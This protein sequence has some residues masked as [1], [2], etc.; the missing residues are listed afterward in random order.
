VHQENRRDLLRHHF[1]ISPYSPSFSNLL[2][3]S[4]SLLSLQKA[5]STCQCLNNMRFY[6]GVVLGLSQVVIATDE[7]L[8][9]RS[10]FELSFL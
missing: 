4:V 7:T 1:Q 10:G 2:S 3:L 8:R 5:F 6:L 9:Q